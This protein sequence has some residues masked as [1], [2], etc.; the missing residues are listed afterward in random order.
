MPDHFGHSVHI[1]SV[2]RKLACFNILVLVPD[3][4]T[5]VRVL[6]QAPNRVSDSRVQVFSFNEK[7]VFCLDRRELYQMLLLLLPAAAGYIVQCV[8]AV[9]LSQLLARLDRRLVTVTPSSSALSDR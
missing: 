1:D 9:T 3:R 7:A 6:F 8:T 4:D 2:S 5:Q